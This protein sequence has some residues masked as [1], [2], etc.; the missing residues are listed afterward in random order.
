MPTIMA[1]QCLTCPSGSFCV[2]DHVTTAP[3]PPRFY[4]PSGTGFDLQ[5]CPP[6]TFSDKSGLHNISCMYFTFF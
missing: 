1:K 6:G 4:C 5:P 2:G 3:C